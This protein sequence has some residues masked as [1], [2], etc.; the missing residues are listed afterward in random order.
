MQCSEVKCCAVNGVAGSN[1]S[2]RCIARNDLHS[3]RQITAACGARLDTVLCFKGPL[4][5][6]LGAGSLAASSQGLWPRQRVRSLEFQSD[7]NDEK[8]EQRVSTRPCEPTTYVCVC[9]ATEPIRLHRATLAARDQ[10]REVAGLGY[11][12]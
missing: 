7:I 8:N 11:V 1:R 12:L 3:T 9:V 6:R 5:S 10:A 2:M 4:T